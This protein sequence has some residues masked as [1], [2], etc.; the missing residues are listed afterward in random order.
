MCKKNKAPG[1][2][3]INYE[4]VMY[5]GDQLCY[6]LCKLYTS[7]LQYSYI[8]DGMKTGVIVTLHKGGRKCKTDPDNYRAI[9]LTSSLLKLFERIICR[10]IEKSGVLNISHMQGG[11]Q[12][13]MGV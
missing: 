4:H 8:P 11:F 3:R 7:M 13:Q 2:D 9:T 5:G 6:T 10:R 1:D 12:R